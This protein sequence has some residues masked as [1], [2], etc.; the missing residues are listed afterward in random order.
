MA[1]HGE[2]H[3]AHRPR[4]ELASVHAEVSPEQPPG[5]PASLNKSPLFPADLPHGRA[6]RAGRRLGQPG[7]RPWIPRAEGLL[8][9]GRP[10]PSWTRLPARPRERAARLSVRPLG[11]WDWAT[12]RAGNAC[13][14]HRFHSAHHPRL[15]SQPGEGNVP[16]GRHPS[17]TKGPLLE[18]EVRIC[19]RRDSWVR[20]PAS[21]QSP[22]RW[23]NI[24][25]IKRGAAC[26]A[27]P[28]GATATPL[29]AETAWAL[30]RA[31]RCEE[32]KFQDPGRWD[33]GW[34]VCWKSL[35]PT[36]GFCLAPGDLSEE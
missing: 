12:R 6:G 4:H 31:L 5:S 23:A 20:V 18:L 26:P 11:R 36:P 7:V 32:R 2:E 33:G 25:G 24:S 9:R 27:G 21:C 13:R 16:S 3:C 14:Q 1:C 22:W 10:A 35:R 28:S 17:P 30:P 29:G 15:L 8:G 34:V 19:G